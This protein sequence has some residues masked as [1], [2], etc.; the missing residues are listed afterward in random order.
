MQLTIEIRDSAYDKIMYLLKN[1]K[2]DV[3]IIDKKIDMDDLD[4]E[5]IDE[6]DP[7]FIYIQKA[8]ERR[9]NGEK[10]YSL[11]EVMKEFK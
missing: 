7:D 4:I 10:T 2:D 11:D 5:V 9:K 8:R 1:L 6:S 3:K